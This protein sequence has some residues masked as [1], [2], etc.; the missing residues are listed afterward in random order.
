MN[1][2]LKVMSR[3][4]FALISAWL[5]HDV[6]QSSATGGGATAAMES[7]RPGAFAK[8]SGDV[9]GSGASRQQA[10]TA[11]ETYNVAQAAASTYNDRDRS[12]QERGDRVGW[13]TVGEPFLGDDYDTET[14]SGEAAGAQESQATAA[15]PIVQEL[16]E[17]K[18]AVAAFEAESSGKNETNRFAYVFFIGNHEPDKYA[19]SAGVN[20]QRLRQLAPNF[21]VDYVALVPENN[22]AIKQVLDSMHTNSTPG[23]VAFIGTGEEEHTRTEEQQLHELLSERLRFFDH[24]IPYTESSTENA[25]SR[26]RLLRRSALS[27][28]AEVVQEAEDDQDLTYE[29]RDRISTMTAFMIAS[30]SSQEREPLFDSFPTADGNAAPSISK[31][32]Y[33]SGFHMKFEAW[34]LTQYE[35]VV[36]LDADSFVL[37]SL[38]H[39]FLLP[40][41]YAFAA[42]FAYWFV[43]KKADDSARPRMRLTMCSAMLVLTP[44][45]AV[46]SEWRKNVE[47]RT[48]RD[49]DMDIINKKY[50]LPDDEACGVGDAALLPPT[51]AVL[52]SHWEKE[53][54]GAPNPAA[55]PISFE[56]GPFKRLREVRP[57]LYEKMMPSTMP[58]YSGDDLLQNAYLIHWTAFGKPWHKDEDTYVQNFFPSLQRRAVCPYFSGWEN[59][60]C[61]RNIGDQP[62]ASC[63]KDTN[64]FHHG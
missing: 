12:G 21:P 54:H 16:E 3:E 63:N 44:S 34:S 38:A 6:V 5:W 42:P 27:A 23:T 51:Y 58:A 60:G 61:P 7:L 46:Y 8:A 1:N 17:A 9:G 25:T 64:Y 45:E 50:R 20:V 31:S 37:K 48:T 53:L 49:Y 36:L 55:D 56:G 4:L 19:C 24:V 28:P 39:L 11:T 62:P 32:A 22:P 26:G 30:T 41:E 18:A 33:Y 47:Q 13:F 40:K 52:N 35:R 59:I 57:D 43:R 29:D 15:C 10:T 14:G 2:V